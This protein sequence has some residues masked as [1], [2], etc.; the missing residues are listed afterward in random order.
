[1]KIG[2]SNFRYTEVVGG[3]LKKGDKVIT[4][5]IG[6]EKEG[7]CERLLIDIRQVTKSYFSGSVETQVLFGVDLAVPRGDFLAVMGQSGSGKS[8]LMNIF[9]CLDQATGG[10]YFSTASTR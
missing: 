6:G 9:G 1:V 5:A 3:E 4:R 8:T 10:S 7:G 2:L